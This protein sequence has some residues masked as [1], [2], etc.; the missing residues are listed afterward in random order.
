LKKRRSRRKKAQGQ[1]AFLRHKKLRFKV[2]RRVISEHFLLPQAK[3]AR[4]D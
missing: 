2:K 4:L 3:G 1:T